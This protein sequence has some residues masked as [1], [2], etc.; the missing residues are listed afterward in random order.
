MTK[1][2][3]EYVQCIDIVLINIE[4]YSKRKVGKW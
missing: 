1:R 4:N 3:E 2:I